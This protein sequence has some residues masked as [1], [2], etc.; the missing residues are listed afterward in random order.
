MLRSRSRSNCQDLWIKIFYAAPRAEKT[1]STV[2]GCGGVYR[3]LRSWRA[4]T[5]ASR[6]CSAWVTQSV[7]STRLTHPEATAAVHNPR[8][9]GS[10]WRTPR[11]LRGSGTAAMRSEER[12]VGKECRS[13]WSPYH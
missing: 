11:L 10:E 4:P 1:R 9:V 7:I 8:I 2:S 5:P 6:S 13:R 3:P 12:R